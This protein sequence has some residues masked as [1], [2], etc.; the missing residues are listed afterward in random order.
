MTTIWCTN[1]PPCMQKAYSTLSLVQARIKKTFAQKRPLDFFS[2][3]TT[4]RIRSITA[5]ARERSLAS[6]CL[7]SI[8]GSRARTKRGL[9]ANLPFTWETGRPCH[10]LVGSERGNNYTSKIQDVAPARVTAWML[11]AIAPTVTQAS[12]CSLVLPL[13]P[14]LLLAGSLL[15]HWSLQL[16]CTQACLLASCMRV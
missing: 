10:L 5:L 15:A 11:A 8:H 14:R 9:P 7:A 4:L 6:W 16:Q 1:I 12:A 3:P 2:L 13:P